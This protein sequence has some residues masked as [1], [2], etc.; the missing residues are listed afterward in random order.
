M[1]RLIDR[2]LIREIVPYFLLALLLLTAIIFAHEASRFSE[3]LVVSSRTGVPMQAIGKIMAALIPGIA[4]FTIPIS[5]LVGTLVGIGRL[6]GDSEIIALGASGMSRLRI[7]RPVIAIALLVAAL[8]L[9]ITFNVLP[10]SISSLNDIK[11]NQALVFQGITTQIKPRIFEESIPKKVLYIE[12]IERT[13]NLWRNIFIVDLSDEQGGM[14]IFTAKSGSLRQ[15]ANVQGKPQMPELYLQEGAFHQT[16][17]PRVIADDPEPETPGDNGASE[18]AEPP[19]SPEEAAIRESNREKKRIRFQQ[20]Y[21]WGSYETMAVGVDVNDDKKEEAPSEKAQKRDVD[22]MEW[23]ELISYSPAQEDYREW[24]AQIHKRLAYPTACLVFALLGVGFGISHVRTGRSFG[25]LLGLGITI[26]YYLLALSGEHSAVSGKLPAWLGVWLANI[27]LTAF[28]SFVIFIQRQP[29]SDV[30]SALSSLRHLLPSARKRAEQRVAIEVAAPEIQAPNPADKIV[31]SAAV[32]KILAARW[33]QL[34]DR[35][36]IG[37]LLRFFFYIVSG[38]SVLFIIITLFQLL[39]SITKHNI[40]WLVVANYL[41]FLLPLIA[42][43]TAPLAALVAVMITFGILQKT[44]QVVALK[45]S[46]FSIFRL[47]APAVIISL[48]LAGLVF[49]NQ[50]YVMPFTNP[51]QNNLRALIRSGQEPAQTFYQTRNQWIFGLDSR[52]FNYA[53]FNPTNNAF[54]QLNVIDLTKEPFGIKRRLYANRAVWDANERVWLLK[55]GWERSFAN[56]K[57]LSFEQ[58]KERKFTLAEQPDYFRRDFRGSQSMTFAELREKIF[59]LSRS[60]FDVLDL[61]IALQSKI[62]FPLTCLI[63]VLVGLP[64]SFSVGKRGALYGVAIGI[65]IGL[66]FWGAIG[67]FE[68]MGRYEILP[69]MLAAWGPNLLFGTGGMYLFLTS[70]T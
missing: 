11:S 24:R 58:F 59:E 69:P 65:A 37:D 9:Y 27:V 14:K 50:D 31:R 56:E 52:I 63:M 22:E 49:F 45:A 19:L 13:S 6:S 33:P 44:S 36:V 64:F 47:A 55:D 67:L 7:L 20:K 3:L 35:L 18:A 57:L 8:M 32:K 4:V 17:A 25:L 34:V 54:A 66:A 40:E 43:Y 48:F 39:N 61:K 12:D 28:G 68:Q 2:Y 29:G 23:S 5:L 41:F 21:T 46:G 15:I 30:F 16:T 38:F 1:L 10:R 42:N 26:V 51:R 53:Y 70:R 62:A 60:G